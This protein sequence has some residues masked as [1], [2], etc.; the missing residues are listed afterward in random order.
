[1][2]DFRKG[3]EGVMDGRSDDDD[4]DHDEDEQE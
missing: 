1:V 2:E 4:D 3:R